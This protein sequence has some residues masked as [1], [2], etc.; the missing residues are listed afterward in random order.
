MGQQALGRQRSW[1]VGRCRATQLPRLWS[2]SWPV[3]LVL[4]ACQ[5]A[6]TY[7]SG[8]RLVGRHTHASLEVPWQ[9]G[10]SGHNLGPFSRPA[11]WCPTDRKDARQVLTSGLGGGCILLLP[12]GG[13]QPVVVLRPGRGLGRGPWAHMRSREGG[14]GSALLLLKWALRSPEAAVKGGPGVGACPGGDE[15]VCWGLCSCGRRTPTH[16]PPWIRPR[17]AAP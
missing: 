7:A 10:S 11:G 4:G 12:T 2:P 15:I 8:L 3:V 13:T 17:S 9:P 14:K 5:P 16:C 1:A 6:D